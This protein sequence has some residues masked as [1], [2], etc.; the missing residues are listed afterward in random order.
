MKRKMSLGKNQVVLS[1]LV[2]MIAVAGYLNYI[3]QSQVSDAIQ[4][5]DT[6]EI[7]ALVDSEES[8]LPTFANELEL[9]EI[10]VTED[11]SIVTE[12]S[13]LEVVE[14]EETTE[15]TPGEA[16]FVS[17]SVD[18]TYFVQAKLEREQSRAK[19]QETLTGMINNEKLSEDQRTEFADE[20]LKMQQR[21]E[22]ETAAEAVIKEKGLG[23]AY[24]RI[25]DETVDVLIN[26]ET[27]TEQEIAQ[28]QDI[29]T[30]KTGMELNQ[31]RISPM[32]VNK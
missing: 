19:Q 7:A 9:T 16:I 14:G 21:I 15:P 27:L 29:V 31:I 23:E 24:V 3:D 11:P 17:S 32:T 26:K 4:L 22:K 5:T 28:I 25:D 20:M 13:A 2:M 30:R 8:L 6:G 12:T 10:D 1:A 18:E